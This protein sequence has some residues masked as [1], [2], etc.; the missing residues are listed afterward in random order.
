MKKDDIFH[1]WFKSTKWKASY[2]ILSQIRLYDSKRLFRNIWN[3][4]FTDMKKLKE[5]VRKLI[6]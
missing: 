4:K 1:Y 6:L 3:I 5:K 2:A